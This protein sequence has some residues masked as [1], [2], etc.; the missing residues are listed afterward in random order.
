MVKIADI[1]AKVEH[2]KDGE[3]LAKTPAEYKAIYDK[4]RADREKPSDPESP[5]RIELSKLQDQGLSRSMP[6][7]Q[8]AAIVGKK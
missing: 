5:N 4:R 6:N 1:L 3:S 2:V 8:E 7:L